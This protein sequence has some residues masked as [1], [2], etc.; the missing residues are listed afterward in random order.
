[1]G[2]VVDFEAHQLGGTGLCV[3]HFAQRCLERG[4]RQGLHQILGENLDERHS[5]VQQ[6]INNSRTAVPCA[7]C[8]RAQSI[9]RL[10]SSRGRYTFSAVRVDVPRPC[11]P[12]L[13]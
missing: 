12:R 2:P 13:R 5:P 3:P 8:P 4:E 11:I 6:R 10:G 1:M 7:A 9:D